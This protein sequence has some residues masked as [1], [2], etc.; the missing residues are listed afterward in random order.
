[1][2]KNK[3]KYHGNEPVAA[4]AVPMDQFVGFWDRVGRSLVPHKRK[5]IAAGLGV[6]A[7][8]GA[9]LVYA[10]WD[11]RR[12]GY[13]TKAFAE[14][15]DVSK[16]RIVAEDTPAPQI[17]PGAKPEATYKSAKER[18]EAE[19][20]ALSKLESSY[21]GAQVAR[22]SRLAKASVLY[23]LGRYDEAI[24]AYKGFLAAK[25]ASPVLV[26][27][28]R[29]GLGYSLEAKA[30]T[31]K[32][33]AN[34]YRAGLDAALKAYQELQPDDKGLYYDMAVY[35]QARILQLKEDKPG[36]IALY[37]KIVDGMPGS[38]IASEARARLAV[39]E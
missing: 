24:A 28:A 20:M 8:V 2:A 6:A 7:M 4:Q 25:P 21:G 36:A 33:D 29:E 12:A 17:P 31:E 15:I 38:Q 26:M 5:L 35:H 10:W 11:G 37:K 22:H 1:M 32:K 30:L 9:Y 19:L 3:G 16:A 14:V 39:L 34:L 18:S 23:D 27:V 13:A